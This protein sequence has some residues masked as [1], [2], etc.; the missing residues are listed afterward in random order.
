MRVFLSC[1]L[2]LLLVNFSVATENS[3]FSGVLVRREIYPA[4]IPCS[5]QGSDEHVQCCLNRR[6]GEHELQKQDQYGNQ[7]HE[8][9]RKAEG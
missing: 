9:R 2:I 1:R 8:I 5:N 7:T 6:R 3:S 4:V